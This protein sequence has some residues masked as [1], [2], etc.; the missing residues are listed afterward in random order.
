MGGDPRT[1]VRLPK[2]FF[3]RATQMGDIV[4]PCNI[5]GAEST[6]LM[7]RVMY[8]VPDV[9]ATACRTADRSSIPSRFPQSNPR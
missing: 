7:E 1:A 3:H 8:R 4:P 5:L 6:F 9:M 2:K